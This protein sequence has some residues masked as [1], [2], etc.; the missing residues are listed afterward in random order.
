MFTTTN[1]PRL[2]ARFVLSESHDVIETPFATWEVV[3]VIE[4]PEDHPSLPFGE[5]L[6]FVVRLV[7]GVMVTD[8]DA[9]WEWADSPI[10]SRLGADTVFFFRPDDMVS[11]RAA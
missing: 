11:A 3:K 4:L 10:V 5:T 6:A 7:K 1:T 9:V 8:D 2:A